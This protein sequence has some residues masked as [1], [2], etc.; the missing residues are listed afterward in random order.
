MSTEGFKKLAAEQAEQN[1]K[2]M[3]VQGSSNGIFQCDCGAEYTSLF[4]APER[5]EQRNLRQKPLGFLRTKYNMCSVCSGNLLEQFNERMDRDAEQSG[6]AV[7][8]MPAGPEV[9]WV[10]G[11]VTEYEAE[12]AWDNA[13]DWRAPDADQ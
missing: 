9:V 12:R 11:E 8:T 5:G 6:L 7:V 1:W 2:A 3:I 4:A 13:P 10:D